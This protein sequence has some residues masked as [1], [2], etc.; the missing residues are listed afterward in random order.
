MK[1]AS[2]ITVKACLVGTQPWLHFLASYDLSVLNVRLI[3]LTF[4][5]HVNRPI[6][7]LSS[8]GT[9]HTVHSC[10]TIPSTAKDQHNYNSHYLWRN[11]YCDDMWRL[12]W[13]VA[14]T[15]Y[16]TP[17]L[18][19]WFQF[20]NGKVAVWTRQKWIQSSL[21]LI[22]VKPFSNQLQTG[23]IFCLCGQVCSQPC[24]F[25]TTWN[26][27]TSFLQLTKQESLQMCCKKWTRH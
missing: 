1:L 4:I 5:F 2:A 11:N 19:F 26:L 25:T 7:Y 15:Q 20:S 23:L 17:E 13:H 18:W 9:V 3:S 6:A 16:L 12:L 10:G 24:A 8:H 22:C 14:I 27:S 21:K